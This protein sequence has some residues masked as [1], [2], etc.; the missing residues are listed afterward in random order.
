MFAPHWYTLEW[1]PPPRPGEK[2]R[3][4]KKT[5]RASL[6]SDEEAKTWARWY[7]EQGGGSAKLALQDGTIFTIP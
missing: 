5:D 3:R 2:R 6:G 7:V 1:T 4:R